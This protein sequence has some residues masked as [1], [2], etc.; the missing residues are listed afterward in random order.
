VTATQPAKGDHIDST[1]LACG[2]ATGHRGDCPAVNPAAD[3]LLAETLADGT[4]RTWTV[5]GARYTLT[6]ARRARITAWL[7]RLEWVRPVDKPRLS[8]YTGMFVREVVTQ[9][10][11][12]GRLSAIGVNELA[13]VAVPD[14]GCGDL[15]RCRCDFPDHPFRGAHPDRWPDYGLVGLKV[16]Y[17][18][19]WSRLW[20]LDTGTGGVIVASD[21]TADPAP[22]GI[23]KAC[24]LGW[25]DHCGGSVRPRASG[26]P[27]TPCACPCRH[28]HL[29]GAS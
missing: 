15:W 18:D 29:G 5:V 6:A 22:A 3:G 7:P 11:L 21:F 24:W 20:L 1:C 14:C 28:T 26:Q 12:A 13:T 8:F 4:V 9:L 23:S 19:G 17:T 27:R 25:C 2:A 16:R 10:D